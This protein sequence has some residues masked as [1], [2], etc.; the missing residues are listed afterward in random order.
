MRYSQVF[1]GRTIPV[2]CILQGVCLGITHINF[3]ENEKCL[4]CLTWLLIIDVQ[5]KPNR[6]SSP[7]QKE[8]VG[9][10]FSLLCALA[11]CLG[12]K[13]G[14]V[15]TRYSMAELTFLENTKLQ[16]VTSFPLI[17]CEHVC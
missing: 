3:K 6:G 12:P 13:S 15:A 8:V 11:R 17:Q 4:V 1:L 10:R 16:E 7:V 5:T 9:V 14:P 2:F